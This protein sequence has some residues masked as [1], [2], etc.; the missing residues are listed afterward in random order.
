[1]CEGS[2]SKWLRCKHGLK[3]GSI[4]ELHL[5][6]GEHYA[7]YHPLN[8]H[9]PALRAVDSMWGLRRGGCFEGYGRTPGLDAG[10]ALRAVWRRFVVGCWLSGP[11]LSGVLGVG[12]VFDEL[13][14]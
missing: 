4:I 1:M 5:S 12:G 6:I 13:A 7:G 10:L 2:S 8:A 11:S 9:V 14:S 3:F